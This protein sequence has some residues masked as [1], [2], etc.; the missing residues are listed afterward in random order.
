MNGIHFRCAALLAALSLLGCDGEQY[1][2]PD[3]A[4]LT[5]TRD[6]SGSEILKACNYVP[7]LLGSQ[8]EKRYP[9]DG[10]MEAFV[11]ITRS[12]IVVTFPGS[13]EDLAPFRVAPKDLEA[14]SVIDDD[15]PTGYT[16]ELG[17]RCTP[18]SEP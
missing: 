14:G 6:R 4:L 12:N 7:V 15:P 9:V 18:D 3:T 2:S 11:T 17:S 16:V 8:V 10:A 5:V 1:V 13:D